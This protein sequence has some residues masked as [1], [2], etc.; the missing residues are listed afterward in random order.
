[1]NRVMCHI[2]GV[3]VAIVFARVAGAAPTTVPVDR[4]VFGNA[5]QEQE[6]HLVA[7]HSDV[8]TGG[9]GESARRLL[10]LEPKDWQGGTLSFTMKVDPAKANYFSVRLWGSDRTSDRLILFCEGKQIGYRHLGDVDILDDANGSP[11]F[12]GRFFYTATPLPV[13]MTK[14]KTEVHLEIHSN[15]RVWGYG[16]NWEQYQRTMTEPTR[17]I[18]RV[19]TH[20]DGCFVP[21]ADEKQGA[22][23]VD[24]P[25][26]K[27]PGEEV[28]T[29]VKA[30]VGKEITGVLAMKTPLN[31]MRMELLARAYHV[32]WSPAYHNEAVVRLVIAGADDYYRRFKQ[33]PHLA[34]SDTDK[35]TYNA[36]WLGLGPLGDAVR[37][38]REPLQASLDQTIDD[39][40]GKQIARREA[41]SQMLVAS[42]DWHLHNRRQYTNQTMISDLFAYLANRGVAAVDLAHAVPE[43]KMRHYLYESIGL[44]PWLG[45]DTDQGPAKSLGDDYW[46]LTSK[47]LT[48][49]LGFVGYYGEVLDWTTS[50]YLATGEPEVRGSGDPKIKAQ[51]EKIEQA[52]SYFRYPELDDDG[53]RAM[54]AETIVGWRDEGHYPGDVTY[55]ERQTWDGSPLYAAAA[56]QSPGAVGAAQQM[57]ADNQFFATLAGRLQDRSLRATAS[58]LGVP[59]EYETIA[60]LPASSSRLPMSTG[61]PDFAWA[62]EQDGVLAVKHGD[63]ILYVSLYW[64]AR[65]AVNFLARVHWITPRVDHIAIVREETEF[66]PSGM[67]YTRPDWVNFGFANGGM[68]YP[69]NMHSAHAGEKLPIARMPA[70]L[71]FRPGDESP[72]AGRGSFYRLR[73]GDYLIGMNCTKE[74]SYELTVPA[75]FEKV[76][77]L[78]SGKAVILNG[79]V[80]V[81]P[82][83]TMVFYLGR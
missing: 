57:F 44:E 2:A 42:R 79:P 35:A 40:G 28:L 52:R 71:K 3:V 25:V 69:G 10:P 13:E 65:H 21:A 81:P 76:P 38:L 24:P 68:R 1:M 30:R 54:R 33:D 62:D 49:E 43:E 11:G 9:L 50:I 41:W 70:G 64:R 19:Y 83:S 67:E 46:Q 77:E 37:L 14:G 31:Q 45:S 51:L 74:K 12:G 17:G 34:E 82:E 78:I 6:H 4:I 55:A 22:A 39:G 58:F 66:E 59:E 8:T 75:G 61:Q 16:T 60:A 20:T 5:A 36:G 18:Y 7:E 47:G 63:E 72:Y 53:N 32:K 56:T 80:R 48:R 29:E 26:R 23:P 15:G 27:A 73:Y